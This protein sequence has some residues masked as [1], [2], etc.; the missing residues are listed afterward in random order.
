MTETRKLAL[1]FLAILALGLFALAVEWLREKLSGWMVLIIVSIALLMMAISIQHARA[2]DHSR[3]S[4]DP[5]FKSL[6]SRAG[7]HCCDGSDFTRLEDVDWESRDGRYRVRIDGE[8][9]DVPEDALVDGPNK[10]GVTMVWPGF[11]DGRPS[12]RCF[13][14]G[15]MG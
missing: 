2:H 1:V 14:P 11:K 10:A 15:S 6:K 13:K 3:P 5:W 12:V 4:L 7:A 8:W 9:V